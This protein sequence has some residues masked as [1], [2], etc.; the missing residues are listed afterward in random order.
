M[1]TLVD[2]QRTIFNLDQVAAFNAILEF[3]TNNQGHFFFI[4]AASS[5]GKTFLYNIIAAEVRKRG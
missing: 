5:C 3:V 1:A 4:H 2:E